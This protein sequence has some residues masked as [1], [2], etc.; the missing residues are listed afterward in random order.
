[1][2]NMGSGLHDVDAFDCLSKPLKIYEQLFKEG[3]M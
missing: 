2:Y 1:M 3:E